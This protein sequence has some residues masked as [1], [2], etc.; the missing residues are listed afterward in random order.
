MFSDIHIGQRPADHQNIM[1]KTNQ[2]WLV[3]ESISFLFDKLDRSK[4]GFEF[5]SGSST[6]WFSKF[7]KEIFSLE[8]D[9][10]WYELITKTI[11]EN[12]FSEEMENIIKNG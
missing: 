3:T 4:V 8:S 1:G 11:K 2:P 12:I 9:R 5:G 10:N 6:F 7:S